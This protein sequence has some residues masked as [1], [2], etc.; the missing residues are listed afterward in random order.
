MDRA[1]QRSRFSF[2]I[3][4]VLTLC[5]LLLNAL[6]TGAESKKKALSKSAQEKI[7]KALDESPGNKIVIFDETGEL[8]GSTTVQKN[9]AQS[10]GSLPDFLNSA[11]SPKKD[12]KNPVPTPP[13]PCI[14]C[15]SG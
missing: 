11:D 10:Y 3:F 2:P 4:F 12:C 5:S 6:P 7:Q 1:S 9:K 13:P 8:T 15:S 14:I